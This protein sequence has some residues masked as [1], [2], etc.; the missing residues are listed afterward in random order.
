MRPYSIV[1]FPALICLVLAFSLLGRGMGGVARAATPAPAVA[2]LDG[3]T[4]VDAALKGVLDLTATPLSTFVVTAA[5]TN[6]II[7]VTAVAAQSN[8]PAKSSRLVKFP[9]ASA[10]DIT[11]FLKLQIGPAPAVPIKAR[12]VLN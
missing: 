2:F 6:Q 4:V 10:R 11:P 1:R 8:P 5:D 9:L 12:L 7:P 3:T